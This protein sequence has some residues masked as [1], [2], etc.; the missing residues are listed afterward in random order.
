MTRATPRI[1]QLMTSPMPT[2]T[3]L[4][5]AMA[6]VGALSEKKKVISNA[7][8]MIILKITGGRD[9]GMAS[10]LMRTSRSL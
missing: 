1:V 5:A 3:A 4:N 8:T 10:P 2:V 6:A 7:P 9:A